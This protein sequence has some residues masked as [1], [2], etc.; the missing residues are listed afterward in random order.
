MP[1]NWITADEIPW[2]EPEAWGHMNMS[3]WPAIDPKTAKAF[4][5]VFRL[6]SL[7]DGTDFVDRGGAVKTKVGPGSTQ[8]S[9]VVC[10]GAVMVF[11]QFDGAFLVRYADESEAPREEY[12]V[13]TKVM[14]RDAEEAE[15]FVGDMLM[16]DIIWDK[17]LEVSHVG[18]AFKES[19][20]PPGLV[21]MTRA[22]EAIRQIRAEDKDFLSAESVADSAKCTA[23]IARRAL[24]V[25]FPELSEAE[26]EHRFWPKD[27][28]A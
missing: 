2:D 23:Q 7:P 15:T 3:P 21:A 8:G 26:L 9:V 5:F 13:V 12:R 25:A 14:A 4:R 19:D 11:C 27:G 16:R 28:A 1:S 6:D 18:R 17:V 22:G 10:D 20:L 24:A